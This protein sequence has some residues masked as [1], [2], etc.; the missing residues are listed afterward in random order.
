MRSG[1]SPPPVTRLLPLSSSPSRALSPFATRCYRRHGRPRQGHDRHGARRRCHFLLL[2]RPRP[3]PSVSF[4]FV[5][6]SVAVVAMCRPTGSPHLSPFP[7]PLPPLPPEWI[8]LSGN[9][10]Y[11]LFK[12][13]VGGTTRDIEFGSSE[14]EDR[15]NAT[16]AFGFLAL[17]AAIAG[18]V[19][20]K[21]LKKLAFAAFG[22]AAF[23]GLIAM[24]ICES[25]REKE[26]RRRGERE[27]CGAGGSTT[28][29]LSPL[30]ILSSFFLSFSLVLYG[31]FA[32]SSAPPNNGR[33]LSRSALARQPAFLGWAPGIALYAFPS[34]TTEMA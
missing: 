32:S 14:D 15:N 7:P 28:W 13:K 27:G 34:I 10:E 16:I 18:T 1:L 31:S 6:C 30:F 2:H 8:E 9:R 25:A 5:C 20:V 24:A 33:T 22:A 17:F 12:S 26:G 21:F 19:M 3:A 11:G 23:C 4:A 29:P